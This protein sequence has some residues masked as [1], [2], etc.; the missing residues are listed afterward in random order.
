MSLCDNSFSWSLL[1]ECGIFFLIEF[2]GLSA[3]AQRLLHHSCNCRDGGFSFFFFFSSLSHTATVPF[4]WKWTFPPFWKGV[5]A[6]EMSPTTHC[7]FFTLCLSNVGIVCPCVL[8][9]FFFFPPLCPR[10]RLCFCF[11]GIAQPKLIFH[12]YASSPL[13]GWNLQWHLLI[14][15]NIVKISTVA[16]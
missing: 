2:D 14:S 12:P 10:V 6:P 11:K 9:G 15:W 1:L 16:S 8:Y 4:N 7:H 5:V 3:V 13:C